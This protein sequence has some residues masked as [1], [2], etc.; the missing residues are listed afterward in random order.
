MSSALISGAA[1]S[2]RRSVPIVS[3]PGGGC[4]HRLCLSTASSLILKGKMNSGR[5]DANCIN[6]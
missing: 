6:L 4:Y 2:R 3:A 5:F 1:A